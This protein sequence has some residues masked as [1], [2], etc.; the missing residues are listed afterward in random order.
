[1]SSGHGPLTVMPKQAKA[2]YKSKPAYEFLTFLFVHVLLPWN[3]QRFSIPFLYTVSGQ[4][5]P[6]LISCSPLLYYIELGRLHSCVTVRV[7]Y[8]TLGCLHICVKCERKNAHYP[9]YTGH[10][11]ENSMKISIDLEFCRAMC[12]C[13]CNKVP[14]V[15]ANE[16]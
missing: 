14:S 6:H 12:I 2:R 10:Q 11:S 3:Q 4:K 9:R 15:D 13:H 7:G 5:Q 8:G 1:M 16:Q